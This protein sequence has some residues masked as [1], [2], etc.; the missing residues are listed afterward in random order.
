MYISAYLKYTKQNSLQKYKFQITRMY[1]IFF[2]CSYSRN[3]VV[4]LVL[5]F[6]NNVKGKNS[7][8]VAI[9]KFYAL[10]QDAFSSCA[11]L[12]AS[13]SLFRISFLLA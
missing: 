1:L 6:I 3:L 12:F 4:Q 10:S 11:A 8:F 2:V 9:F 7:T 5:Y 13:R